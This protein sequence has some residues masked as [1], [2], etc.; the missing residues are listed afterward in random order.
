M[1]PN[2]MSTLVLEGAGS[3]QRDAIHASR[4]FTTREAI[5][6]D[7]APVLY[8]TARLGSRPT[9]SCT[10]SVRMA[11]PSSSTASGMVDQSTLFGMRQNRRGQVRVGLPGVRIL[12]QLEG[13][14]GAESAHIADAG[15][16]LGECL[17]MPLHALPDLRRLGAQSLG[18]HHVQ[19]RMRGRDADAGRAAE[20]PGQ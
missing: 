4:G 18:L 14:H 5:N 17:Q 3:Y 10:A 16:L 13:H 12:H 8:A 1:G 15:Q 2:W 6:Y 7:S 9:A 20:T 11:S 19:D